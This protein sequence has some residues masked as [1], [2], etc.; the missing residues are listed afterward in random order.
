MQA[1]T[2]RQAQAPQ[3]S[4]VSFSDDG[5]ITSRVFARIGLLG[6]PSDG[7]FGKTISLSLAN[8]YAEVC[9]V[10]RCVFCAE[11]DLWL[12][13]SMAAISRRGWLGV[14]GVPSAATLFAAA[15]AAVLH[16]CVAVAPRAGARTCERPHTKHARARCSPHK[17]GDADAGRRQHARRV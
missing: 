11:R 5:S 12:Q 1:A 9:C 8:F 3:P 6:N 7:F 17:K 10:L 16:A 13:L 4:A 2:Q 14:P 15:A